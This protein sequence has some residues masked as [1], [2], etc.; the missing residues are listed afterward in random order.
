MPTSLST[1]IEPGS[2]VELRVPKA[3][4]FGTISGYFND[5]KALQEAAM[6]LSGSYGGIYF[7]CNP[8]KP[9]L[10]ARA[11]NR[12]I[13]YSKVTTADHD[14]EKRRWIPVD[15]DPVRPV[16]ISSTDEE[17]LSAMTRAYAVYEHLIQQGWEEPLLM[18]SGNGSYV[19]I[20]VDL[21]NDEDS[22]EL[23]QKFLATLAHKFDDNVVHVDLTMFNAARI[24]R[25]PG[26]LNMKGDS[27]G[28][29]PHR[30]AGF[31]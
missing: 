13:R 11:S 2:V 7:T 10:L 21:P 24:I 5:V 14:V 4:R 20:R 19:L 27:T 8:V 3:E 16:G 6:K 9:A 17:H 29:R 22:R 26:T 18:D 15:L 30:R 23:V 25:V 1:L 12:V 31:L 28:D